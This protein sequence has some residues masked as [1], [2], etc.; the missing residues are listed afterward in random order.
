MPST[1][2]FSSTGGLQYI[3]KP[4]FTSTIPTPPPTNPFTGLFGC[5]IVTD[6]QG[7]SFNV[8][9]NGKIIGHFENDQVVSWEVNGNT[10]TIKTKD[11]V[12]YLLVFI[13]VT[14]ALKA[15][16]NINSNMNGIIT[17]GC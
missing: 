4:P 5:G 2:S 8:V 9:L 17:T 14:E 11:Q 10:I 3:I 16:Q 7:V 6:V 13:L 12:S 1:S 15:D